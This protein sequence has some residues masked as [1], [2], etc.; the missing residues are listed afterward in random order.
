V[1]ELRHESPVR[2]ASG[3]EVVITS[4]ELLPGW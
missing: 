3:V 1:I 2:A 4:G